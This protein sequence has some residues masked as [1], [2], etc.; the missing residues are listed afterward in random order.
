MSLNNPHE[1]TLQVSHRSGETEDTFIDV[2]QRA[3]CGANGAWQS[4]LSVQAA[5]RDRA[6]SDIMFDKADLA[7]GLSTGQIKRGSLLSFQNRQ[8]DACLPEL[9]VPVLIT[10]TGAPCRSERVAK[11]RS[12]LQMMKSEASEPATTTRGTTSFCES[13]NTWAV[14]PTTP[15]T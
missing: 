3:S 12:E 11:L 4:L 14:G 15:D 7:V 2:T 1:L 8:V 6:T 9:R 10:R 5:S 13:K